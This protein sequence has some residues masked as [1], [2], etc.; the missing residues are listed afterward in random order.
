VRSAEDG[1]ADATA[2]ERLGDYLYYSG[3]PPDCESVVYY[4]QYAPTDSTGNVNE[5][6]RGVE[7]VVLDMNTVTHDLK[8]ECTYVLLGQLKLSADQRFMAFTLDTTGDETFQM[9]FKDLKTNTLL[10]HVVDSVVNVVFA[11]DAS[12]SSPVLFYTVADRCV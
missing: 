10:P 8:I 2:A 6:L 12:A 9:Y 1:L 3:R 5:A 4:R 11:S 7:E